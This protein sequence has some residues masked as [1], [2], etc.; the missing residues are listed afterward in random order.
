MGIMWNIH[1][2][3][4]CT[5]LCCGGV[6]WD[7][8]ILCN[9]RVRSGWFK[10]YK[11]ILY[12]ESCEVKCHVH[13]AQLHALFV[14]VHYVRHQF[15]RV[16]GYVRDPSSN[17]MSLLTSSIIVQSFIILRRLVHVHELLW[18]RTDGH[19]RRSHKGFWWTLNKLLDHGPVK[20]QAK[21][22]N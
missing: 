7:T 8:F 16:R 6:M 15:D 20:K 1:L 13:C 5:W 4:L 14:H 11:R 12:S 2:N 22:W 17:S 19:T 10:L 18:K 21:L 3:V 9:V